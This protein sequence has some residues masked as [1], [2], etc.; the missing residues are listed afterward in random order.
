MGMTTAKEFVNK[1]MRLRHET[2]IREYL[3][4]KYV[5]DSA[6]WLSV[7]YFYAGN[8]RTYLNEKRPFTNKEWKKLLEETNRPTDDH[9]LT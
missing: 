9:Y 3:A 5:H 1:T 8:G 4:G 7:G 2:R 6:L